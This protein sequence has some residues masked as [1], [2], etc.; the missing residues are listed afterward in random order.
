MFVCAGL[1]VDWDF[2]NRSACWVVGSSEIVCERL[3]GDRVARTGRSVCTSRK[4]QHK[5]SKIFILVVRAK[6]G[7]HRLVI[8]V[9]LCVSHYDAVVGHL[10]DFEH[11]ENKNDDDKW[12]WDDTSAN[13]FVGP[14]ALRLPE[15]VE[16]EDVGVT[17]DLFEHSFGHYYKDITTSLP[18]K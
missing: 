11:K 3:E 18:S 10:D 13:T 6:R 8:V 4:A 12:Q 9:D 1:E 17:D 15:V 16:G 5:R 7:H 2:G 14:L